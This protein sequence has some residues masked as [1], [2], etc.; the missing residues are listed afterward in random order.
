MSDTIFSKKTD[1]NEEAGKKR[2]PLGR[3]K[4]AIMSLLSMIEGSRERDAKTWIRIFDTVSEFRY[5][6]QTDLEEKELTVLDVILHSLLPKLTVQ[7]RR[8]FSES[9]SRRGVVSE[10]LT[11]SLITDELTVAA[12]ILARSGFI[13]EDHF[14][15][16][17]TVG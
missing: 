9:L 14:N 15:A 7:H 13:S 12:P 2:G 11:E 1:T 3:G 10:I 16:A 8:R 5:S 4:T 6:E 17:I